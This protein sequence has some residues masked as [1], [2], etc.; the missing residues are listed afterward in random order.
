MRRRELFERGIRA[1][2]GVAASSLVP[3]RSVEAAQIP[4]ESA[5]PSYSS[6]PSQF[7]LFSRLDSQGHTELALSRQGPWTP[8]AVGDTFAGLSV[9][10][11]PVKGQARPWT[12]LEREE[13]TNGE[14][15]YVDREGVVCRISKPLG[16][17]GTQIPP[18]IEARSREYWDKLLNADDDI[19]GKRYLADP[20]DPSL[21]RTREVFPP[22]I[23]PESYVGMKEYPHEVQVSWDGSIGV[24]KG[25]FTGNETEEL[26]A[27]LPFALN[28]REIDRSEGLQIFQGPPGILPPD[29]AVRLPTRRG[30]DSVGSSSS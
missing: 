16:R 2:L 12:V 28:D 20:R 11:V 27:A 5:V 13:S 14:F 24:D 7:Q 9:R 8:V 6:S 3:S 26:A 25:F 19:L 4:K 23:Y 18:R 1:S 29:H 17:V 22:L 30:R 15:I 10:A 21:E